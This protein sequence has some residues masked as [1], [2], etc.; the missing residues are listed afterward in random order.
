MLIGCKTNKEE[1][2]GKTIMIRSKE[3]HERMD[4]LVQLKTNNSNRY[5]SKIVYYNKKGSN[6]FCNLNLQYS[7]IF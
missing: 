5:I 3:E 2:F 1:Y 7:F 4:S 6:N